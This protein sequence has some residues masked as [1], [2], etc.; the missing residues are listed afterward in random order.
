MNGTGAL[1][2]AAGRYDGMDEFRPMLKLTGSTLIQKEI[3]TLR[4]AGASPIVVVTG[5]EGEQLERH[6]SHRGVV[7]IRNEA[8]Y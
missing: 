8:G 5:Y 4:K 7:C 6:L 1:I 2:T 3:D